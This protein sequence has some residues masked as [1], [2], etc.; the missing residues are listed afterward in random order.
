MNIPILTTK[1]HIPPARSKAVLRSHLFERLSEGQGQQGKV[2]LISASAGHGKT[3]L[4][5]EW[6]A[7]CR[8]RVAWL[9]L[10]EGDN[11][12]GRFLLHLI[13]AI[14]NIVDVND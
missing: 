14:K 1:L 4:V 8:R 9:S 11:D 6:L 13:A 10:D 2:T 12:P 5:S 7:D 3:T